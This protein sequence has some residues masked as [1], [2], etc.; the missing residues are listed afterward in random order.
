[1]NWTI[2]N[3]TANFDQSP[4]SSDKLISM[5]L[6]YEKASKEMKRWRFWSLLGWRVGKR[7]D[8]LLVEWTIHQGR[9]KG[10]GGGIAE[11][12]SVRVEFCF[13]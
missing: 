1:M 2:Q 5:Q 11:Y 10:E 8:K 12:F 13:L 9:R 7:V 6:V 4:F 3:N